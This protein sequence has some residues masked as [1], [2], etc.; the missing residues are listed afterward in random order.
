MMRSV[1]CVLCL[2]C[3]CGR[4]GF[5]AV[6]TDGAA[7]D[8]APEPVG[9]LDPTFATTGY[10]LTSS[11]TSFAAYDL[12][13]RTG[14]GYLLVGPHAVGGSSFGLFAYAADGSV[15]ASFG[16]GGIVDIGPTTSDFAYSAVRL[17]DGRILVSGDGDAATGTADDITM[18]V[19]DEAGVPDPAF[20]SGGFVRLDVLGGMLADT[21]G[22]SIQVGMSSLIACGASNYPVTD[23]HFVLANV[24]LTGNLIPS[25]GT[26][27]MVVEDFH[28]G[29]HD[30][31]NDLVALPDGTIVAVGS[32][33]PSALATAYRLDGTRDPTFAGGVPLEIGT[34]A[35]FEGISRAP[36]GDLVVSGQDNGSGTVGMLSP[37][38]VPRAGF[39][40]AGFARLPSAL[41]L[42][43]NVVQPDGKVVAVGQSQAQNAMFARF[44]IDGSLDPS[45]G[46]GGIV[47]LPLGVKGQLVSVILTG[48]GK[49]VAAG[50]LGGGPY[51]GLVVRLL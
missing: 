42:T 1:S 11:L 30:G 21:S 46:T 32:T 36:D 35:G 48:D 39:G 19:I 37:A 23:S 6:A 12:L 17:S 44:R 41:F 7:G 10:A 3:G 24:S 40:Q 49:L 29:V 20:G 8:G 5:D 27:G 31:C 38:G 14:A 50:F 45:F 9:Q 43:G 15:D 18:G 4:I 51:R 16:T 34:N 25:F 33:G 2:V 22:R 47:E 13:E 26:N 28:P